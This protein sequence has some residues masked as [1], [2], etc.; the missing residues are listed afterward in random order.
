VDV[1]L[2][3]FKPRGVVRGNPS[4]FAFVRGCPPGR[5]MTAKRAYADVLTLEKLACLRP[6]FNR[7]RFSKPCAAAGASLTYR[8]FG[9]DVG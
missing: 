2:A 7:E 1:S 4:K 5:R 9:A 6:V 3:V 8:R